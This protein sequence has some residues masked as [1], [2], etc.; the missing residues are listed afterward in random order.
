MAS[1]RE[2]E[3]REYLAWLEVQEA[4]TSGQHQRRRQRAIDEHELAKHELDKALGRR[5]AMEDAK[6]S[7]AE[8]RARKNER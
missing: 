8:R 5:Q 3:T 2:Y 1:I 6:L 7:R 4:F